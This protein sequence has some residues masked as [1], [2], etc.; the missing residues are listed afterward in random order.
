MLSIQQPQFIKILLG[1]L[2]AILIFSLLQWTFVG[3]YTIRP[4]SAQ[5]ASLNTI[6]VFAPTP[7]FGQAPTSGVLEQTHLDLTLKGTFAAS[8]PLAGS[9]VISAPDTGDK[10]YIVEDKLPG[11]ATIKEIYPDYVVLT[12]QDKQ[13]VLRLP[14]S[15]L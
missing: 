11:G 4:E 7:L 15:G 6:E 3:F 10:V 14:E 8:Q 9:A 1:A 13:Q 12:Y 2:A 5:S